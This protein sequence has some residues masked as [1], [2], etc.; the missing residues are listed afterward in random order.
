MFFIDGNLVTSVTSTCSNSSATV[1]V[2]PRSY[3][4]IQ[5]EDSYHEDI[6]FRIDYVCIGNDSQKV[7]ENMAKW[8]A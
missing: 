4:D 2:V 1:T 8:I 7:S 6:N 3:S 5:S